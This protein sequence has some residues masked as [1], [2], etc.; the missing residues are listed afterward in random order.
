MK[1]FRTCD[2]SKIDQYTIKNE[3]ISDIDL[4][5][6]ASLTVV[7]YI[8]NETDF[9]GDVLVFCGP[10]NNGGDGLAVARLLAENSRFNVSVFILNF[11]K[12]LKGSP[13]INLERI[14]TNCKIPVTFL[15]NE[16]QLP[17]INSESLVVDALFG[18]GL[19]R[20]LENLAAKIVQHINNSNADV[21]SIDIP[22]GL[23]GENNTNNIS[24][25]IIKATKTITFQFSKLSFFF[26]ENEN[27][28]PNWSIKD[29]K[30]HPNAIEN[31]ESIFHYLDDNEAKKQIK[32]RNKFSHKGT[33]GHA[34]LISGSY[35]K[36]GASVLAS[37]ACLRSGVGL[38][39]TH[40]PRLGYQII[41][42]SI[43]EAMT[44]IDNSDLM[45][46]NIEKVEIYSSIGIGPGIGTKNNT[47]K[48]LKNLIEK[49]HNPL[50]LDADAI[51]ILA[52][53]E[54]LQNKLPENSILTPHP[55]EFERLTGKVN[56]GYE[57]MLKAQ[58]YAATHN[59]ILVVK[60]AHTMI[61][62]SN[63]QVWFNSTGNP[64]MAT[65][66]SGDVLT[67]IILALLAQGYKSIDAAKLG[68]YIH[69]LAG[70][71]ATTQRGYEALIASDIIENLGEAF[72]IA[73]R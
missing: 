27:F 25:N 66:G 56:N 3:P 58:E 21:L 33:Y 24:E 10:G 7:N 8:I 15:E 72:K 6:R 71:I 65:A 63:K 44:S 68:V 23:M 41:Q 38:L 2:I 64:G 60:G 51:N 9:S 37:K 43:P 11:G 54:E 17:N 14:K 46:S 30:L 13:A 48:G 70:D 73:H 19:N 34:L 67:G 18:S 29:I 62:N 59:V 42:S 40:I 36:M 5:E 69:G 35:G 1:I 52:E 28:I 53:D 32:T 20:P 12:E 31:T 4:M 26:P 61:V 57:R 45:F 49:T 22:S 16:N 39:T 55:K 50:V 47:R